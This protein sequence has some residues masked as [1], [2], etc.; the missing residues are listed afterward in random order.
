MGSAPG[1]MGGEGGTR[2]AIDGMVTLCFIRKLPPRNGIKPCPGIPRI[3]HECTA[4]RRRNTAR[5]KREEE[6]GYALA[7]WDSELTV[8]DLE[9]TCTG[10]LIASATTW[11]PRRAYDGVVRRWP[12]R[13]RAAA[14]RAWQG[15]T[16]GADMADMSSRWCSGSST[17]RCRRAGMGTERRRGIRLSSRVGMSVEIRKEDLP[18][19]VGRVHHI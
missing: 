17:G 11:A 1:E 6:E 16:T 7:W 3:A 5:T 14:G 15:A 18:G 13:R 9:V 19:H 10:S 8:A 12:A 4:A 2:S